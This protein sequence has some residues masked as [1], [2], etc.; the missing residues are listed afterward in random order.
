MRSFN[1]AEIGVVKMLT[2]PPNEIVNCGMKV[3][4]CSDNYVYEFVETKWQRKEKAT[5]ENYA[6]IPQ[7]IQ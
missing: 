1:L 3:I 7:L 4:N 6:E 2:N 5:R